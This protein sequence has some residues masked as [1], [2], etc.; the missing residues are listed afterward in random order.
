MWP[1]GPPAGAYCAPVDAFWFL[2]F[3]LVALW[4]VGNALRTP[5]RRRRFGLPP[6][7][8]PALLTA[9]MPLFHIA[10]QVIVV[11]A[12]AAAGSL[13]SPGG[14]LAL[15]V[16]LVTWAGLL[17]I[18]GTSY[19]A[20]ATIQ[21]ELSAV[22]GELELGRNGPRLWPL[23]RRPRSVTMVADLEYG[24]DARHRLDIHRRAGLD[25]MPVIVQIH[26]GGWMRGDRRRQA[27]PLMFELAAAG[28]G[29][30]AISYRLSPRATFPD[31]VI[32]VKRAIA[33]I[34]RHG[35][36]YGLDP[37]TVV[38]TGG[39][40]GA[41]L[42]ALAALTPN[43]PEY[44]P[45]FE[46]MDTSVDGCVAFYGLFDL[47]REDGVTPR[48]PFMVRSVLKVRPA[49]DLDAWRRASPQSWIGPDAPPFFILHGTHDRLIR[50]GA[51]ERFS[52]QLAATSAAPVVFAPVHGGNHGFDYFNS[53]RAIAAARG[54]RSFLDVAVLGRLDRAVE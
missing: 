21:R 35:H 10:W 50:I 28:W 13:S 3:A 36:E 34:R 19:R 1:L 42:A 25:G 26:G 30:V 52:A 8:L 40:A 4:H 38:L 14:Y 39:S 5:R 12:F 7:W 18:Y 24:P 20:A 29:V 11:A 17:Y 9:E 43:A 37:S 46:D 53:V 27:R 6:L 44:Q 15:A 54:V 49:D 16:M 23:A 47:L 2:F 31:H 45:G 33:W 51:S 41:H 22:A 48:W 32:D